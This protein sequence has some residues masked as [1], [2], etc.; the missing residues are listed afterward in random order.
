MVS[1]GFQTKKLPTSLFLQGTGCAKV[2]SVLA[3]DGTPSLSSLATRHP[4]PHP[5]AFARAC[6]LGAL[7]PDL[8]V[9]GSLA[10][11]RSSFQSHLSGPSLPLGEATHNLSGALS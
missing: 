10:C 7:L 3:P 4:H 2:E 8:H 5:R 1:R 9:V 11:F 6:L